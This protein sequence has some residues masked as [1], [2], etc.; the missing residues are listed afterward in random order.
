MKKLFSIEEKENIKT[1]ILKCKTNFTDNILKVKVA[2]YATFKKKPGK[3]AKSVK[4]FVDK[5][6]YLSSV[7]GLHMVEE[8]NQLLQVIVL[9]QGIYISTISS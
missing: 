1:I 7:P 4:L 3:M 2:D 5:P 9:C 6:A 8:K